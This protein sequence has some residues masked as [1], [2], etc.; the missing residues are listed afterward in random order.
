MAMITITSDELQEAKNI[1]LKFAELSQQMGQI[2][3]AK[4]SLETEQ[5]AV[6]SEM[7]RLTERDEQFVKDLNVKYGAGSLNIETGEFTPAT[8]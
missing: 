4:L 8:D 3:F 6:E 7:E 2:H 1:R 5:R